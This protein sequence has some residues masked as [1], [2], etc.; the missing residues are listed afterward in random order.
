MTH[1]DSSFDLISKALDVA[2]LRHKVIANNLANAN[3]PGYRR[4]VV[5]FKRE[6]ERA[7]DQPGP[8]ELSVVEADDPPDA[9]GN[10]VSFDR[11]LAEL[12]KNSLIF[13][14]FAQLADLRVKALRAAIE[15]RV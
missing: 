3:V 14:T 8:I 13:E 2:A 11:E 5:Q 7:L 4:L 12:Q 15:G 9:T 10:N 6:L 1:F